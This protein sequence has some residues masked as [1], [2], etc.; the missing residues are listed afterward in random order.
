MIETVSLLMKT[1]DP[2]NTITDWM[3]LTG[4]SGFMWP[5]TSRDTSR[6]IHRKFLRTSSR[7]ILKIFKEETLLD[8][9]LLGNQQI[10][11]A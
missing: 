5:N 1:L 11:A 10:H 2:T 7:Q 8:S 9:T 6:N 4:P 3:R